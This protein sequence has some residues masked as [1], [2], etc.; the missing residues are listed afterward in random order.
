[1]SVAAA[2]IV[3]HLARAELVPGL[4]HVQH[5]PVAV[6]GLEGEGLVGGN[7]RQEARI[8]IAVGIEWLSVTPSPRGRG[9][10]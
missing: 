8:G 9:L 1:M 6:D 3:P 5:H 2:A 10:G 4:G 7:L